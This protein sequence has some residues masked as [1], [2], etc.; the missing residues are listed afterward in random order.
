MIKSKPK[1]SVR[2]RDPLKQGLKQADYAR[3]YTM[4]TCPRERSIKTRIETFNCTAS[5][6]A[7]TLCPRERSIK[8]RIETFDKLKA[9]LRPP[10]SEREI[11]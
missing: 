11:H 1:R 9:P 6:T 4:E 7:P 8:T 2:E 3:G 10:T 5:A